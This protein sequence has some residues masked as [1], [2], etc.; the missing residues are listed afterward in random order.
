[1][2][3][4]TSPYNKE[5]D[6]IGAPYESLEKAKEDAKKNERFGYVVYDSEGKLVYNPTTS[7]KASE[8]L[9]QARI[10][11]DYMR[12]NGYSYGHASINPAIAKGMPDCDKLCSCDRLV[13]WALYN[14]GFTDQPYLHGLTDE[15][16]PFMLRHGFTEITDMNEL[17]PGDVIYVGYRDQP[18]PYGHV[19]IHAGRAA[20]NDCY[21]YDAGS[22]DRIRCIGIYEAYNQSG[23]P[24]CQPLELSEKALFR[25]AYRPP[26]EK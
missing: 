23:Q 2:Y 22:V 16:I 5:S 1:M 19:F 3:Y 21:R 13:S 20:Q 11:A 24:F 6:R 10:I 14:A 15:L 7:L 18:A 26:T 4:L 17:M 8:I 9:Y 25:I 12:K